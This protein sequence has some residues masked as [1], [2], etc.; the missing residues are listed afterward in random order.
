[1]EHNSCLGPYKAKVQVRRLLLWVQIW[2]YSIFKS[3]VLTLTLVLFFLSSLT[4]SFT[5]LLTIFLHVVCVFVYVYTIHIHSHGQGAVLP[6]NKE[7]SDGQ[8]ITQRLCFCSSFLSSHFFTVLLI[9]L[10]VYVCTPFW[11]CH[12]SLPFHCFKFSWLIH[13]LLECF[14]G[15]VIDANYHEKLIFLGFS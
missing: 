8:S 12:F 4:L 7:K 14:H 13:W 1:M 2:Y 9:F 10:H 11:T 5:I 15:Q 3:N 6:E